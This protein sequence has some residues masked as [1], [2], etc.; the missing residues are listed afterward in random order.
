MSNVMQQ[1]PSMNNAYAINAGMA[2][3][4]R[5]ETARRGRALRN[6]GHHHYI[7]PSNQPLARLHNNARNVTP[8]VVVVATGERPS[9]QHVAT[10]HCVD[11][12]NS[13]SLV[14]PGARARKSPISISNRN[15]SRYRPFANRTTPPLPIQG[16]HQGQCQPHRS[17]SAFSGLLASPPISPHHHVDNA[18]RYYSSHQAVVAAA[19]DLSSANL[20]HQGPHQGQH[21]LANSMHHPGLNGHH[22]HNHSTPYH[23]AAHYLTDGNGVPS[24]AFRATQHRNMPTSH[25]ANHGHGG[26]IQATNN[27]TTVAVNGHHVCICCVHQ[28]QQ[29]HPQVRSLVRS[30]SLEPLISSLFVL[31]DVR[32]VRTCSYM[33]LFMVF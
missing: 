25:H 13:I 12:C 22:H 4:M 3:E 23:Y 30:N 6:T 18:V 1:Q 5:F 2:E 27:S 32:L 16:G 19:G 20:P 14:G 28:L 33:N 10:N 8:N 17:I 15:G 26:V 21:P 31:C 24:V 11:R 29:R 7:Q 9:G